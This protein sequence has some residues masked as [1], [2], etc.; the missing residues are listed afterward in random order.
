VDVELGGTLTT[1][2]TVTDWR[3]RWGKPSNLEVAVDADIPAFFGRFIGR[4]GGLAADPSIV[5][6]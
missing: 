4:V 1:G 6:R 3:R 5:A 2:E